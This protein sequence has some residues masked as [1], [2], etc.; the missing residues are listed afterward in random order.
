MSRNC[1]RLAFTRVCNG[2]V[3]SRLL[4]FYVLVTILKPFVPL[5]LLAQ[6]AW[7][8]PVG[9]RNQEAEGRL[10]ARVIRLSQLT[11][12]GDR[13]C[14][15]RSLLLYRAL[16]RAGADPTLVVGFEQ[17]D[18]GI[19]GHAWVVVDGQAV[20]ES[21]ADLRRY[22]RALNFGSRGMLNASQRVPDRS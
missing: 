22:S 13:D 19:M 2:I 17:S 18:D 10:A 8:A 15:Q 11:G 20:L 4:P 9:P 7:C 3:I 1:S 16:S 21:D 12:L 14:V 5:Q 6:W